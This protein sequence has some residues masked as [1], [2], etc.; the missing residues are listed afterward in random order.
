MINAASGTRLFIGSVADSLSPDLA[1]YQG[2]SY[3][4]VEEVESVGDFGDASEAVNFIALSDA[5]VRKLKGPRDAGTCPVVC[6]DFPGDP[7]QVALIAAEATPFD[8]HFKVVGNDALTLG[9]DNSESFF[10][11]KVMGKKKSVGAANNVV[12]RTF[13]L[14]INSDIIEVAST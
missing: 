8:Y 14:G 12:K 11:A 2:D 6:G 13:D 5:R 4:E 10:C 1:D 3:V 9:G 7:G